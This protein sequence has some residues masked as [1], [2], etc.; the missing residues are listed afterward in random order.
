MNTCTIE[1]NSDSGERRYIHLSNG[2]IQSLKFAT[3]LEYEYA[4]VTVDLFCENVTLL[5]CSVVVC[6]Y[7]S[8]FFL[9]L[10]ECHNFKIWIHS[11]VRLDKR[12]KAYKAQA[13]CLTYAL[14]GLH[15][16]FHP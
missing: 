3:R 15:K 7:V 6:N 11:V 4:Q 14:S 1:I 16:M 8:P 9:Y 13:H 5:H 10:K 12:D 2:L